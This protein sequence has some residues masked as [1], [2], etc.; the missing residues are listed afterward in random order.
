M[1]D[2]AFAG[3]SVVSAEAAVQSLPSCIFPRAVL[4][5]WGWGWGDAV[6]KPVAG[7]ACHVVIGAEATASEFWREGVVSRAYLFKSG[8]QCLSFSLVAALPREVLG[9]SRPEAAG[10]QLPPAGPLPPRAVVLNFSCMSSIPWWSVRDL[11]PPSPPLFLEDEKNFLV[12]RKP[13]RE[14][15]PFCIFL[16]NSYFLGCV[17]LPVHD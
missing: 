16:F 13:S 6:V 17:Q 4:A 10:Q 14:W 1:W 2:H 9:V 15:V 12:R 8:V 5:G 3:P 11:L 7:V